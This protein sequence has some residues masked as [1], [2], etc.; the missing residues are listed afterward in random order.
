M[1]LIRCPGLPYSVN[2]AAKAVRIEE[3][4]AVQFRV[5]GNEADRAAR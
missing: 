3:L 2:I 4:K 1:A 5:L